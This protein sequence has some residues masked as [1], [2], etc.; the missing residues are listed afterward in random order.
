VILKNLPTKLFSRQL[1]GVVDNL[2][3]AISAA[4]ENDDN[5]ALLE[6]VQLTHREIIKL[7]DHSMSRPLMLKIS[8]LIPIFIRP[9]PRIETDEHPE[10]TVTLCCKKDIRFMTGSS[11]RPWLLSQK[12]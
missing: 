6:G 10:N 12:N 7:F 3:R 5:T 4:E 9:S 11:D 2:E 1:L 8:R